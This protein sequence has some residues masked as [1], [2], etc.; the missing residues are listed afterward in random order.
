MALEELYNQLGKVVLK[1][2]ENKL[3]QMKVIEILGRYIV[4][5]NERYPECRKE[6]CSGK[7]R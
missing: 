6:Y 5:F 4:V 1:N 2:E 7:V 3:I